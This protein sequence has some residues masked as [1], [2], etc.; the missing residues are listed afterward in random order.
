MYFNFEN[1]VQYYL[2]LD[3]NNKK[4]IIN[5]INCTGTKY[6]LRVVMYY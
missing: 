5:I 1:K 2:R 4:A 6:L 3:K